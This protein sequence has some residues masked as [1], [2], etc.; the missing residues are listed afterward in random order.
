[1][2]LRI[3]KL[4]LALLL[5]CIPLISSQLSQPSNFVISNSIAPVGATLSGDNSIAFSGGVYYF[6]YS[7]G[8]SIIA[9]YEI[10]TNNND[11]KKGMLRI[12]ESVTNSYPVASGGTVYRK[13]DGNLINPS[14]LASISSVAL[15][16]QLFSN[17]VVSLYYSESI[18][19][20]DNI[21]NLY[22]RFDIETSG[23]SLVIHAYAVNPSSSPLGNYAGL[24]FENSDQTP[25]SEGID[26]PFM[27][28]AT[29]TKVNNNYFYS[30]Y[31]DWTKS[32]SNDNPTR[33][34]PFS[35]DPDSFQ[36][37]YSSSYI[38]GQN[39][40]YPA[41]DETSYITVSAD[42]KE[43][44]MRIHRNPSSYRDD[45][46]H[47]VVLD[48]FNIN[49][50][51]LN[52]NRV[53]SAKMIISQL[54]SY[55]LDNLLVMLHG[56]NYINSLGVA[57]P[58]HW[59]PFESYGSTQDLQN[60]IQTAENY[61]HLISE[62][63]I[64][65]NDFF[66]N[67]PQ[68][69]NYCQGSPPMPNN[70]PN[71]P[72]ALNPDGSCKLSGWWSPTYQNGDYYY[73]IA[74]D[75]MIS[76]AQ[77]EAPTIASNLDL[78]AVY[79]DVSPKVSFKELIDYSSSNSNSRTIK[80][81]LQRNIEFNN[82]IRNIFG[83]PISGEGGEH[84]Q[85]TI[86]TLLAGNIDAV[87][88]EINKREMAPVI[89][90]F[91]LRYVKPLMANQGMGPYE[92][93]LDNQGTSQWSVPVS[94]NTFPIDKY[95]ATVIAFGH[96]GLVTDMF[97]YD[98][99]NGIT[100]TDYVAHAV[101][102]YYIFRKLQEEYLSSDIVNILYKNPSGNLVPL[103]QAMKDYS[104]NIEQSF[105]NAQLYLEYSNGLKIYI[106]RHQSNTWS[107]S[108]QGSSVYLPPNSWY[109]F[110]P[111]TGLLVYSAL[112]NQNGEP[113]QTGPYRVDYAKTSDYIMF[114]ARGSNVPIPFIGFN[115]QVITSQHIKVIKP[116]G[117]TLSQL[118]DK[119]FC[120]PSSPQLS[121]SSNSTV[122]NSINN[123]II[124]YGENFYLNSLI[125]VNGTP[126][127]QGYPWTTYINSQ[128]IIMYVAA[129]TP[130]GNYDIKI[131]NQCNSLQSNN[132]QIT[133]QSPSL[134]ITTPPSCGST[135]PLCNGACP[136]NQ[137]CEQSGNTC[138]CVAQASNQ[139][140][141]P[142][143]TRQTRPRTPSSEPPIDVDVPTQTQIK[144]TKEKKKIK[145]E[146]LEELDTSNFV[147]WLTM[148]AVFMILLTI[149]ILLIKGKRKKPEFTSHSVKIST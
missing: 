60:L 117:W 64:D 11:I 76:Y 32:N 111:N 12:K 57:Y 10:D 135:Y 8:G 69:N 65:Y 121:Y 124:L 39:N 14:Q 68:W 45:L 137:T 72:I 89:P 27:K 114:D 26:I 125:N 78:S 3:I 21:I 6:T 33:L 52:F 43:T 110:N 63:H 79:L 136:N 31:I 37:S 143:Q 108:P 139:P 73:I 92:R 40:V 104:G 95:R 50:P 100:M 20:E 41:F 83:G 35:I 17:G 70:A 13:L 97:L 4:N 2:L 113:S 61:G 82:Y 130:P 80:D 84:Y 119:T 149:I 85:G 105:Y 58:T 53:D 138:Q 34:S 67:S 126:Y 118:P 77:Q 44:F 15:Q 66:Q 74:I 24:S 115:S 38:A 9:R 116:N 28:T 144:T 30:T 148:F 81:G 145:K 142:S 147:F 1:M 106:N 129:N 98:N 42:I 51:I 120:P 103:S 140:S 16:H 59:P 86:D 94:F 49:T 55:G 133:V 71:F 18:S 109:A 19:D 54:H 46:N 7:E 56:G 102:E 122:I 29:V 132:L 93:W 22:K 47:R 128:L 131:L 62:I 25:N 141:Q 96:T 23:K 127:P 75:K 99:P 90:D 87:V 101:K 88:R 107:I 36:N 112:V 146:I 5:F 134:N 91:E 48:I 123:L